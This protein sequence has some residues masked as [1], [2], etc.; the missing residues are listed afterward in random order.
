MRRLWIRI[1]LVIGFIA[2]TLGGIACVVT[3]K[4]D[5]PKGQDEV[6]FPEI[7]AY[8]ERAAVAYGSDDEIRKKFGE[9]TFIAMLPELD[10]KIFIETDPATKVQ[11]IAVRGTDNLENVKTDVEYNEDR[12]AILGIYLHRGFQRSAMAAYAVVK[13]R[14]RRDYSLRVT[15]HSLGGAVAVTRGFVRRRT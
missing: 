4:S 15:G 2:V 11:W 9:G 6:N 1:L 5:K 3:L 7:L 10:V 13:P 8:A 14:L 12:D